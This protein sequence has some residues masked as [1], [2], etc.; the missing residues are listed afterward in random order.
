MKGAAYGCVQGPGVCGVRV[1][2]SKNV[3]VK[4]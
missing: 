2:M 3:T 1:Y 4:Y